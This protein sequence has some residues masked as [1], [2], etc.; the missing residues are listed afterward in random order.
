VA[1]A[2]G[3]AVTDR[4]AISSRRKKRLLGPTND[5]DDPWDNGASEGFIHL[6]PRVQEML[7]QTLGPVVRSQA[8]RGYEPPR[9]VIEFR[10]GK[11]ESGGMLRMPSQEELGM[12]DY[13]AWLTSPKRGM[14][15]Y[16]G[17]GRW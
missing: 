10:G 17:R 5:G 8:R 13:E 4:N 1:G 16:P 15:T 9:E 7:A 11:A 6:H 2:Y 14:G 3:D 12:H